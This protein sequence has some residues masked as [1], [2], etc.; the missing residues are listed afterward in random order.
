VLYQLYVYKDRGATA[1]I[2][3]RA[4]SAGCRG[5]VL[6]ADA[7]VLGTRWRDVRNRFRLPDGLAIPNAAPSGR[8][9][10]GDDIG[11]GLARYVSEQLDPTLGWKDVEWL[12]AIAGMPVWLKGVVRPDD[13]RR[14]A[15]L[16]VDGIIVSNHG[17][18]QLDGG[19]P[20]A[21]ALPEVADAVGGR[22]P[23]WVDGGIRRGTD[24]LK[25]L[26]L[27]ASAVLVGRPVLWGLAVDGEA[28]VR[29]VL[30]LLRD[31]LVEAMTLLGAR[32]PSEVD[33][34]SVR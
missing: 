23:V 13:A 29:A 2:V 26:A 32:S 34:S 16:G 15:E 17:G 1:E 28:G 33:R 10:A 14:A 6:T 27:G 22:I 18:R 8:S 4:R 19:V 20:T 9:L 25:A 11:S 30:E 3:A 12:R 7:A 21:V 31:E 24:V 5:L